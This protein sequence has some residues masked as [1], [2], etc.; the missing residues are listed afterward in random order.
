[1]L[2]ADYL[3]SAVLEMHYIHYKLVV[4]R[5]V[6]YVVLAAGCVAH[7]SLDRR[8]YS[9]KPPNNACSL[10]T[11]FYLFTLITTNRDVCI[12]VSATGKSQL[13]R[14]RR[15]KGCSSELTTSPQFFWL[16]TW[17]VSNWYMDTAVDPLQS[18]D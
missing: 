3:V 18:N 13:A 16:D 14:L 2:A 12:V 4:Q 7:T 6:Y 5:R 9:M 1:M 11:F 17:R 8:N 10:R 15:K